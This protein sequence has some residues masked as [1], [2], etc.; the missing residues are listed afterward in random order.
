MQNDKIHYDDRAGGR[1]DSRTLSAQCFVSI[2]R[3]IK[4]KLLQVYVQC[5]PTET[6]PRYGV[7]GFLERW[8]CFSLLI[9]F[10]SRRVVYRII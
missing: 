9:T 7:F 3:A 4:T 8:S 5:S 10:N 2:P 6:G 1:Q